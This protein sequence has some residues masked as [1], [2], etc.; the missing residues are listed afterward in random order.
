LKGVGVTSLFR[1]VNLFGRRGPLFG[2]ESAPTLTL[3]VDAGLLPYLSTAVDAEFVGQR[4][5]RVPPPLLSVVDL[6]KNQSMRAVIQKA[7]K[8]I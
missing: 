1:A 3:P 4:V 2:E 6:K 5:E 8:T 7:G